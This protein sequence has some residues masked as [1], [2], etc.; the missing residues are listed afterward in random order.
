MWDLS[1]PTRDWNHILC[2]WRWILN[3]L[4]I[5]EVPW[6]LLMRENQILVKLMAGLQVGE[7]GLA[8]EPHGPLTGSLLTSLHTQGTAQCFPPCSRGCRVSFQFVLCKWSKVSIEFLS[9]EALLPPP[10]FPFFLFLPSLLPPSVLI[11]ILLFHPFFPCL[12]AL[13]HSTLFPTFIPFVVYLILL[14]IYQIS[15][16]NVSSSSSL[17][18]EVYIKVRIF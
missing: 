16:Q 1:S 7:T 11:S 5:R 4:T 14:I 15:Y 9:Y 13:P 18:D 2:I 12:S 3:H 10:P 17:E 6:L 8:R